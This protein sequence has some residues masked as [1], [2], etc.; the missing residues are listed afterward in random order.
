MEQV[1]AVLN[2]NIDRVRQVLFRMIPT[3]AD[4]GGR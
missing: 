2:A 1:F 3:I 4:V